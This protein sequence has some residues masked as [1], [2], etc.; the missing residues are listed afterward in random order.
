MQRLRHL[1]LTLRVPLIA[2]LMMVLVGIVASQQVLAALGR[3][4]DARLQELA[5][6]HIEGLSV[7]LG[8]LVLR[9]DIWEIYDTLD[10]AGSAGKT[11]RMVLTVVAEESGRVLA[12]SDPRRVPVD[13]AIDGLDANAQSLDA[14]S[15]SGA[16]Q[17]LRVAAP[18]F[19][20]GRIVGSITTELDVADL[21]AERRQAGLYL[22]I[23][24]ALA[25]GV[26]ALGGYL[27]MRRMLRP[28]T[29]LVRGMDA[30]D[31]QPRP[32]PSTDVPKGDTEL[33]RLFLTYNAMTHAVE[34]RVEAERRLAERERF[35]S[36]GRLSSSLAHEINNP[37]GGLLNATD[38]ITRYAERPQV[39][40]QSAALLERGLKHLR[41]VVRATLDENRLDHSGTRL[42]ASDFDDL[43]LLI[44]PET[45]RQGQSL[46]WQVS[47]APDLLSRH[48]AGSLRQI[49]LN[50]LLNA[51]EAADKGGKI[52][53]EVQARPDALVV[54]VTDDGPGLPEA[55]RLRLL[56]STAI[57][58]GGGTGLRLVRDL[59]LKEGGEIDCAPQSK[60]TRIV[61]TFP[62]K[63]G[64][65]LC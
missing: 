16:D 22:L 44:G 42:S 49:I 11:P 62:V 31:G 5:A 14:V 57:P 2:A 24:N 6:L 40:R 10:R 50:L 20:Q 37:L 13:S 36:L 1:P 12:A 43:R 26:L 60:G 54:T 35:V 27:A 17:H 9:N 46:D 8:P 61:L 21:V 4:Q 53:L 56:T 15:I 63:E 29:V 38:T 52:G 51:S 65:Q 64:T 19:Y 39:V 47:G 48:D 3:V 18:L 59:V 55:A 25:T 41:D 34:A 58:P 7:A 32:I 30:T 28:M 45:A 23:G 33:A